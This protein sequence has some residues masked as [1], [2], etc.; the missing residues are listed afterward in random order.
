MFIYSNK[1]YEIN[2]KY[3]SID[4][5]NDGSIYHVDETTPE[6]SL[7]KD[8][9]VS[10]HPYYDLVI[11]NGVL[12][13]ITV[14]NPITAIV[15]SLLGNNQITADGTDTATITATVDDLSST[16]LIELYLDD[17]LLD[18]KNAVNGVATFEITMTQTGVLNLTVKSTIKYGQASITIEGVIA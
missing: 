10:S 7:I 14:Y 1:D 3:P 11:V 17:T 13:D 12:T 4:L 15:S 6:G 18:S 2:S 9:I 16:E 5:Y 8:K